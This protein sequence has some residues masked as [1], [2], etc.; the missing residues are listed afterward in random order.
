MSRFDDNTYTQRIEVRHE[1]L[2]DLFREP[3]LNLEP[4]RK[5]ICDSR[6]LADADDLVARD[7]ADVATAKEGEHVVLTNAVNFDILAN[8]EMLRVGLKQ[9]AVD[10]LVY[11]LSVAAREK[12][13]R[14]G[15]A[16]GGSDQALALRVFAQLG[17]Q[18]F[19]EWFNFH[20]LLV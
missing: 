13:P 9:S 15:N 16:V 11:I 6:E 19:N 3:F 10:H 1:A 5:H 18:L 20:S 8:H 14:L 7:I 2:R 4:P 12:F 17:E